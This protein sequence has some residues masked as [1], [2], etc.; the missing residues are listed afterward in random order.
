VA[1]AAYYRD[2]AQLKIRELLEQELALVAPAEVVAKLGDDPRLPL[3]G[4]VRR[5]DQHHL[6]WAINELVRTGQVKQ[7][8]HRTKGAR[9]VRVIVP[10]EQRLRTRAVHDAVQRKAAL[11]ARYLGWA[12]GTPN[13]P[14]VLGPAAE[15]LVQ[16]A[17]AI[18]NGYFL[19]NPAT[20]QTT[21]LRGVAVPGGP[22][23]NAAILSI[24]DRQTNTPSGT[25]DVVVEVKNIRPWI[26]PGDDELHQLLWKAATLQQALPEVP[27][28]P[29]LVCRQT[30]HVTGI[31]TSTLGVYV[32]RTV[33]QLAPAN[34]NPSKL[35]EVVN[36]LGYRINSSDEPAPALINHFNT[37]IPAAAP[38]LASRWR[39]VGSKFLP[40]YQQLRRDDLDRAEREALREELL[41]AVSITDHGSPATTHQ[42]MNLGDD[43]TPW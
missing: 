20:G 1:D 11:H 33:T 43:E 23:D 15:A 7:E 8:F 32:V 10:A 31:L 24:V 19:L 2:L 30:A 14:G 25:F 42:V 41:A 13:R 12:S 38:Q 16:R 37:L 28:L 18:A 4:R 40:Y 39:T 17:L 5:I 27:I 22:L 35:A 9:N 26:Y 21:L 29:V 6:G 36:E 3:P 34:L